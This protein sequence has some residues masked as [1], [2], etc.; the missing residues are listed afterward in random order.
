MA[1]MSVSIETDATATNCEL[2]TRKHQVHESCPTPNLSSAASRRVRLSHPRARWRRCGRPPGRASGSSIAHRDGDG[3]RKTDG[4]RRHPS[5]AGVRDDH[6]WHG[7][8]R[9]RRG[10]FILSGELRG[11]DWFSDPLRGLRARHRRPP[12]SRR[13]FVRF[14]VSPDGQRILKRTHF[15]GD[16]A[17]FSRE[18]PERVTRDRR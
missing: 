4:R 2:P 12:R 16:S 5:T 15:A 17:P 18:S 1:V 3:A 14:L 13:A 9:E 8:V 6:G 10:S 11:N 7:P